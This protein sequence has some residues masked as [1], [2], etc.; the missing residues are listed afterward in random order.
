MAFD[1]RPT[2]PYELV[3]AIIASRDDW[4]ERDLWTFCAVDRTWCQLAQPLLY[5]TVNM[6]PR[7]RTD[8]STHKRRARLLRRTLT[9]C[10][11]LARW[12]RRLSIAAAQHDHSRYFN[13]KVPDGELYHDFASDAFAIFKAC[14]SISALEIGLFYSYEAFDDFLMELYL[15]KERRITH[16]HVVRQLPIREGH[17]FFPWVYQ[18]NSIKH[19]SGDL[20][21]DDDE[22]WDARA[23]PEYNGG[24]DPPQLVRLDL[25]A[26]LSRTLG[27]VLCQTS[28]LTL[29]TVSIPAFEWMWLLDCENIRH[30]TVKLRPPINA[31]F[32]EARRDLN[33]AFQTI[34][35]CQVVETL[36]IT[37]RRNVPHVS[38]AFG[39]DETLFWQNWPESITT[40]NVAGVR[41]LSGQC[42]V[43]GLQDPTTDKFKLPRLRRLVIGPG[44]MSEQ[45]ML[46]AICRQNDC[47]LQCEH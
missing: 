34:Q 24:I 28:K 20:A 40:L 4:S 16:V 17:S 36:V 30:V 15:D 8:Y 41:E 12:P 11:H 46:Q 18:T 47:I 37:A 14:P 9:T 26:A 23:R 45:P 29:T 2:L 42:L 3:S 32:E 1:Q 13:E 5:E 35:S 22:H 10:A 39:R 6:Q 38:A 19:L 21:F 25:R 31:T 44:Q 7:I 33:N 43:E 27:F